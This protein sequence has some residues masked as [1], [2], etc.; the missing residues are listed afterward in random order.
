MNS[1]IQ[2]HSGKKFYPL[3]PRAKDVCIEDIAHALALKCRF[4]GQCKTFYSIAQHSVFV[5]QFCKSNRTKKAA[6][7][8]DAAEAYLAD[9]PS[10]VKKRLRYWKSVEENVTKAIFKKF[11]ITYPYP[12]EVYERD[13]DML[14]V[15][16]EQL[17]RKQ[18]DWGLPDR[19]IPTNMLSLQIQAQS[20][21]EAE[22]N[23]ILAWQQLIE[24]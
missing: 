22:F 19:L 17:M 9:I 3:E 5:S 23:F 12:D 24:K 10:P 20:A 4:N 13:L 18:M 11:R 21:V 14:Y 15:E 6:L 7:L 8:H 1:W 2:T 16:Q